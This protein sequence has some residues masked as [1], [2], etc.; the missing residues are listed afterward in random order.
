MIQKARGEDSQSLLR[1]I[2]YSCLVLP[3]ETQAERDSDIYFLRQLSK[4]LKAQRAKQEGTLS[5]GCKT[6]AKKVRIELLEYLR[7]IALKQGSRVQTAN[8]YCRF[9][10]FTEDNLV[11]FMLEV[12][13]IL[14]KNGCFGFTEIHPQDRELLS[15]HI[16]YVGTN[17]DKAEALIADW[18]VKNGFEISI[19]SAIGK[20]GEKRGYEL[21]ASGEIDS[22]NLVVMSLE[23]AIAK[24]EWRDREETIRE[25][26]KKELEQK[27]Q[28][29]KA[30]EEEVLKEL[31][32][33]LEKNRARIE[34]FKQELSKI[35]IK[36]PKKRDSSKIREQIN[37]MSNEEFEKHTQKLLLRKRRR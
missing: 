28:E 25:Q 34:A 14:R 26:E 16:Q 20:A 35:T 10:K 7:Q 12:K 9:F 15:P 33:L 19:E 37:T 18:L 29:R 23:G 32:P 2:A 3:T 21:L 36:T 31:E 22:S 30:L 5:S 8:I 1:E 11:K 6:G 27:E 24:Q 4:V 17:A 13:D